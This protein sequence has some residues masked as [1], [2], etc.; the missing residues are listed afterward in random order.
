[1][2][3]CVV[4]FVLVLQFLELASMQRR[5]NAILVEGRRTDKFTKIESGTFLNSL[6]V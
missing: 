3:I 6:S 1:M 5:H 4:L 2:L